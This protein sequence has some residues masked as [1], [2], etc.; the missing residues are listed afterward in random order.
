[1]DRPTK[2]YGRFYAAFKRIQHYGDDEGQKAQLVATYTKGRTTHLH[3]MKAREYNDLCKALDGMCGYTDQRKRQRS[4]VLHLMQELGINTQDWQR[5]N[6]FCQNPRIAGKV[7]AQLDIPE[8]EALQ[9]KL[10]AI[11]RR[12]GLTPP[13]ER[14]ERP[15]RPQPSVYRPTEPPPLLL[16]YNV[17]NNI[18]R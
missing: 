14:R 5:V 2:N 1:M 11:K 8:L 12:G 15:S 9:K 18:V 3:E 6:D 10:R 13:R 4:I 16:E 7:F 17:I